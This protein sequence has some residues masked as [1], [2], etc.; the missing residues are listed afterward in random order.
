VSTSQSLSG[1]SRILQWRGREE[2]DQRDRPKEEGRSLSST[3]FPSFPP[4][5]SSSSRSLLILLAYFLGTILYKYVSP[6]PPIPNPSSSRS[7]PNLIPSSF[8]VLSRYILKLTGSAQLPHFT[9]SAPSISLPSLS[10]PFKRSS[11][12]SRPWG[13]WRRG[14]GYG[15]VPADARDD[16]V[17]DSDEEEGLVGRFG[18]DSDDDDE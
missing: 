10:N 3:T 16:E 9:C 2:R 11:S 17:G 14:N 8:F 5:F 1:R 6:A 4:P 15:R 7:I 12:S 18:L 13:S